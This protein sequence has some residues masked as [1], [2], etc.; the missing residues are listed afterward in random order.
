MSPARRHAPNESGAPDAE[1]MTRLVQQLANE[2]YREGAGGRTEA[3]SLT[4][5]HTAGPPAAGLPLTG[6]GP[7]LGGFEVPCPT[8]DATVYGGVRP[9]HT[10][11]GPRYYFVEEPPAS[12][13][14]PP[15]AAPT[16]PWAPPG[17]PVEAVR[18]D[19]PALHQ[20]VH[21]R[22]LVWLDNAATTHKPQQ[23]ID[24][25]SH[26]YAHD[27]SNVH[28]GAHTLAARATES[29]EGAR[30]RVQRW[31]GAESPSEIVF[32]RG[33]TEG[34]N[35][36]AQAYGRANVEPGDEIV[37]TALEH[38][39]NIVPWQMLAE[40]REAV[41]RVAPITDEG[42][43]DLEAFERL[44]GPRTR[45]V[46]VTHASNVLGTV[47]P[48]RLMT[49]LAHGHGARVL[50]DGAQGI[51]HL[52][53]D[54]REIGCDFYT[55][56]GHKMFGPTGVGVLYGRRELLERMPPWQGGG[57]MIE[58]VT[59]ERTTYN[60]PPHKFE[61]GTGV[62]AEAVG[63]GAALDYLDAIGPGAA[64]QHEQQLLDHATSALA[65]VPGLRLIGTARHKVAVLSFVLDGIRSE[66][67]AAHL[68]RE[69][70]AVRAGHHCAQPTMQRFGLPG[71][72]RASLAFYNTAEEVDKLAGALEGLTRRAR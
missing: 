7:V 44:L 8:S 36:V 67:V 70:I 72:V 42:E 16:S 39:A 31:L 68:D 23:V 21:G 3:A 63:L 30:A 69:G 11:T 60:V 54:V 47:L 28:R 64:A 5:E 26:F 20:T 25:V 33:T 27:N 46:A 65:A 6:I 61:A 52:P 14:E 10:S 37:L 38:H 1:S 50:V 19:F 66:D 49:S 29:Y 58:H 57:N 18:R 41:L 55:F 4:R 71:T 22:S 13:E 9:G 51:P 43:V 32:V 53:T 2:A 48:L 56:S 24:A 34:I 12:V 17:F 45:I 59:F 15:E 35:L 62:L 40:E